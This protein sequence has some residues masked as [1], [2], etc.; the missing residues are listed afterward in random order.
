MVYMLMADGFETVEA[1][2]PVDILRRAKV[3]LQLA[4]ADRQPVTSS[5]GVVV[6][7][8]IGLDGVNLE[9]CDMLILPGGGDGVKNLESNP[10][11]KQLIRDAS[12][13]GVYI[14][15]ICAAPAILADMG[16]L[17][18]RSAVC[19]PSMRERLVAGGAIYVEDAGVVRDGTIVT[20]KAAGVS[21]DF[22]LTLVELLRDGSTAEQIKNEIYYH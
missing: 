19:H 11:V 16:L 7:P 17:K 22:G 15:A 1:L 12:E 2:A 6:Q 14:A 3:S 9:Q 4:S 20:A 5:H 18:G 13:R 8:D 21:L 10:A